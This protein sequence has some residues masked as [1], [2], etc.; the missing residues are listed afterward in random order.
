M[1]AIVRRHPANIA[2]IALNVALLIVVAGLLVAGSRVSVTGYY[3]EAAWNWM[4]GQSMYDTT[5]TGFLYLPH[6]AIAYIPFAVQAH[7]QGDVAWRIISLILFVLGCYRFF[8]LSPQ[9]SEFFN[10]SAGFVALLLCADCMR[11]GQATVIMTATMLLAIDAIRRENWHLCTWL[12]MLGFAVKP[13]SI[14]L[15]LLVGA[16]YA[17]MRWRL[18]VG[19]IVLAL[20]PFAFQSPDYVWQQ[21]EEFGLC[22]FHSNRI[23]YEKWWAQLF[24]MLKAFG[25]EVPDSIQTASR[26]LCAVGTLAICFV[27]KRKLD[28]KRF[29]VWL[30]TLTAIYLMLFNPR[31][32]NC[33]YCVLGPA[34]G[35]FYAEALCGRRWFAA[36]SMMALAVVILGSFELGQHITPQGVPPVWLAPLACCFFTLYAAFRLTSELNRLEPPPSLEAQPVLE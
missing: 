17:P 8:R 14:V 29:L 11:N 32:E 12:L 3:S 24:G 1:F 23:G 26:M 30:Y 28:S 36:G 7:P 4:A 13:L 20:V 10:L 16:L 34:L 2:W 25:L 19:I 21:Y 15:I 18:G 6:S 9:K 22:L 35:L 33:T 5:G 27:L 31:T